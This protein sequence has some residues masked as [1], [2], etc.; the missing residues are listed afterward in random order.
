MKIKY[1]LRILFVWFCVYCIHCTHNN[2]EKN[3]F[4]QSVPG[5]SPKKFA[6]GLISSEKFSETGCVFTKD[7]RSFYFTRSGGDLDT[8]TIFYRTFKKDRWSE[9]FKA[10][11]EGFGPHLLS[12]DHSM[13]ISRYKKL[14]DTQ[15]TIE[16]VRLKNGTN[17]WHTP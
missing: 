8:P 1:T 14:S 13:I 2:T 17:G 16:L 10:P 5:M 4:D 12:N 6:P 11:F 7:L 9:E 3:A 15:R